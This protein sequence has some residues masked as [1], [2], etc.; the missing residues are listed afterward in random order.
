MDDMRLLSLQIGRPQTIDPGHPGQRPWQTSI[1]RQVVDRPVR[2]TLTHL[3]GDEVTDKHA[4]GG[5]DKAV[6]VYPS[7]HYPFWREELKMPEQADGGPQNGWFGENFT[8]L[9]MLEGGVC[10]GDSYEIGDSLV[11][12]SQPRQPCQTLARRWE[13]KDFVRRVDLAGRMGWYL[14]VLREGFVAPG[15]IIRLV[16]RPLPEWTITRAYA[17]MTHPRDHLESA[18]Q[19]A[20]CPLLSTDWRMELAQKIHR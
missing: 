9:G 1:F 10:I 16:E 6:N 2:L 19:L 5:V 12:V 20:A 8:T 11:Q 3:E 13:V 15:E 4:H 18:R 7:E 14:R 17:V